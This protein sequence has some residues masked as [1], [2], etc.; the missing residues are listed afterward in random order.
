MGAEPH[1]VDDSE[2]I[3]AFLRA[4][5]IPSGASI[6]DVPCGIG[7]RALRLAK[8][9]HPVVAV[10]PN[11]IGIDAARRR[12]PEDL[13]PRL[14]YAA[15]PRMGLPNL[16]P[17]ETFDVILSLDHSIGRGGEEDDVGFLTRLTAHAT[18]AGRLVLDFLSRDYIA[19]R[20]RPFAF[21][22]IGNIERHEFRRF[23]PV[24]GILHLEWNFYER[25]G[26]DLTFRTNS[27]VDLRLVPPHEVAWMLERAGW[28]VSAFYGGWDRAPVTE[29]RRKIVLVAHPARD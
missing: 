10:D 27:S 23:D 18:E 24:S 20:P 8:A 4:E 5:G 22:V 25:T 15:A 2:A 26:D 21:H 14:T 13:R 7:R 17:G 19:S 16:A 28:R 29:G 6:L 12:V 11:E 1:P 3:V 9:G